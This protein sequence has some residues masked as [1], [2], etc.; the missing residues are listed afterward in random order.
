MTE[1]FVWDCHVGLSPPRND[2]FLIVARGV[3][4]ELL[5]QRFSLAV[6]GFRFMSNRGIIRLKVRR[7]EQYDSP[8]N[9]GKRV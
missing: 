5:R 1:D 8:F 9:A 2:G 3:F 7:G 6:R 4:Q